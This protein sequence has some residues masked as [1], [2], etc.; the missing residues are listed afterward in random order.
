M[1][2]KIYMMNPRPWDGAIGNHQPALHCSHAVLTEVL[3][4][5]KT[6]L[7]FHPTANTRAEP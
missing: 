3:C 4:A 2:P 6:V 5:Q 7:R 1:K